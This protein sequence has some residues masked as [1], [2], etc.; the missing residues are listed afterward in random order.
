MS[1]RTIQVVS[2]E[3]L[4][5][6][7]QHHMPRGCFLMEKGGKWVAVDNSTFDAWREEFP[8][9][10]QAIHWLQGE[11]EVG[12]VAKTWTYIDAPELLMEVSAQQRIALTADEA[13]LIL[14]YFEGHEYSLMAGDAGATM[15]HDDQ[16]GNNHRGDMPYSIR[17]AIEF[18]QEQNAD[19]MARD[20]IS[21]EEYQSLL[22]D[23]QIIDLLMERI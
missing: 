22:R 6:L 21:Q 8:Q 4:Q 10:D 13:E 3:R 2:P 9:K 18:C 16:Y 11:I 19:L 20:D 15:R 5:E 17:D 23:Q 7:M 1:K 14:G 12:E